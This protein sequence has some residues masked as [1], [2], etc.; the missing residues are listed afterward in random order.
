VIIG[1]CSRKGCPGVTTLA[2]ALALAWPGET[3]LLEADPW[4][5]VLPF[6][7]HPPGMRFLAPEPMVL[8][9]AL[10]ART[11]AG[12]TDLIRYTQQTSLGVKVIPGP[13]TDPD[14]AV[15]RPMWSL[16]AEQVRSWP[17][18]V[19]AD[20]GR[21]HSGDE[22]LELAAAADVVL[23]MAEHS[24]DG[25]FHARE[26]ATHLKRVLDDGSRGRHR[27]GVVIRAGHRQQ[28][29]AL[30]EVTRL[31]QAV[32]S[33]VPVTGWVADDPAG[34]AELLT[35]RDSKRLR[36]SA[37]MGSVEDLIA[38]MHRIWTLDPG[39]AMTGTT[40]SPRRAGGG[41]EPAPGRWRTR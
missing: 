18:T 22:G 12:G 10:A 35:G 16:V 3:V 7:L 29:E 4:G 26:A 36:G 14:R 20:L 2:T 39:A 9:L 19:V 41:R 31:L 40:G 24:V 38:R 8:S 30:E 33:P 11:S 37:L 1:V 32:G 6:R 25:L 13:V 28:D 21:L 17:G 5:A 34:V 23:V 15:L 27:V